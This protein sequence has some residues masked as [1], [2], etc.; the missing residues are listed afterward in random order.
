MKPVL[1]PPGNTRL[2]VKFDEP[3][4]HCA[5]NFNL[6]RYKSVKA[7]HVETIRVPAGTTWY[8]RIAG[9]YK[10]RVEGNIYIVEVRPCRLTLSNPR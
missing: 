4:S 10:G 8:V 1:K 2:K 6:R 3:V 7:N 5:S 9:D